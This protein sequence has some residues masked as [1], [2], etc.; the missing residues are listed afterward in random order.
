MADVK[1]LVTFDEESHEYLENYKEQHGI[2]YNGEALAKIFKEHK[3]RHDTEWSLKYVSEVVSQNIR[4]T[5][6]EDLTKFRLGIN[7]ADKNSQIIIEVL[8]GLLFH[9]SVDDIL[10]T[11]VNKMTAIETATKVVEERITNQR[12]KRIEWEATRKKS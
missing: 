2:R 9:N 12:Q 7:S 11:D 6:K 5:L 4:E 8:N 1:K 10:T 3:N